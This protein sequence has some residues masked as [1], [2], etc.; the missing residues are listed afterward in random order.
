MKYAILLIV[1]GLCSCDGVSLFQNNEQKDLQ[2]M[3]EHVKKQA[4]ILKIHCDSAI[5][6][7]AI[8][9]AKEKMLKIQKH[10]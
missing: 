3:N 7:K 4:E 5:M 10:K 2:K 9:M 1:I 6:Q 8:L